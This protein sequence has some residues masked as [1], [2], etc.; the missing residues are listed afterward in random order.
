MVAVARTI[1]VI[2]YHLLLHD[3]PCEDLGGTYFDQRQRQV[4][5]H[6]LKQRLERPGYRVQLEPLGSVA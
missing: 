5:S 3:H 6:R 1:L 2:A 4:V